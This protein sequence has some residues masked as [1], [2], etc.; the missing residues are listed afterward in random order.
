[1]DRAPIEEDSFHHVYNRGTD[2]R[3]IFDDDHDYRRFILYLNV[4]NDTD[5]LSPNTFEELL[6][7]EA[8]GPTGERLVNII[9]FCLM[10]NHYHLLLHERTPGGISKFMQRLGTAY[11]MYFNEKNDRSGALFQGRFKSKLVD[12]DE[13]IIK[14]IDYI[15]LN[16]KEIMNL[17]D[18]RWSSYHDYCGES[19][20]KKFLWKDDLTD[21]FEVPT[22]YRNWLKDQRDFSEIHHIAIDGPKSKKNRYKLEGS[23]F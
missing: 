11:T 9:A 14:V 1:M 2:K 7:R 18:Y 20:F 10:P 13:Y 23:T 22:E 6:L 16:P 21:F 17:S 15:H 3:V 19:R 12:D 8:D 4:L 5:I